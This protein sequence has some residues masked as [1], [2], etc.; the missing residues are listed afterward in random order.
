MVLI[1]VVILSIESKV[2]V[3]D[4]GINCAQHGVVLSAWE[5]QFHTSEKGCEWLTVAYRYRLGKVQ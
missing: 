3:E 5:S 1:H 2:V 4:G